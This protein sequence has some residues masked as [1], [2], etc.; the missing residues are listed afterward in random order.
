[1]IT[2]L[3]RS[4]GMSLLVVLG[5]L[6][7]VSIFAA[8][9]NFLASQTTQKARRIAAQKGAMLIARSARALAFA[10]ICRDITDEKSEI[11]KILINPSLTTEQKIPV[12]IASLTSLA[13]EFKQGKADLS[14][15]VDSISP[16]DKDKLTKTTGGFDEVER[17]IVLKIKPTVVVDGISYS[18]EELRQVKIFNLVPGILGKFS[19][20]VKEPESDYNKFAAELNGKVDDRVLSPQLPV[21]FKNG[22]TLDVGTKLDPTDLDSWKRR[23]FI[24]LGN[25]SLGGEI[26]LN[27]TAGSHPAYGEDFHF[28]NIAD[29]ESKNPDKILPGYFEPEPAGR[30]SDP[31]KSNWQECPQS[32]NPTSVTSNFAPFFYFWIKHQIKGFFTASPATNDDM[33]ADGKLAVYFK[34]SSGAPNTKMMSSVLHLFGTNSCPSPTLVLGNVFRRYAD[35]SAIVVDA[36]GDKYHDACLTYLNEAEDDTG[37]PGHVAKV[38][39][40]KNSA[41]GEK[42]LQVNPPSYINIDGFY[43]YNGLM[44]SGFDIY[45]SKMCQIITEPYLRSHDCLYH[46]TEDDF[47]PQAS[48]F[49]AA[50]GKLSLPTT[51]FKLDLPSLDPADPSPR[52]ASFFEYGSLSAIPMDYIKSKCVFTV[53]SY[54]DFMARFLSGPLMNQ[55][56]L[57]TGVLI[58]WKAGEKYVIPTDLNIVRGGIIVFE[59]GDVSVGKIPFKMSTDE[60]LIIV[61]LDGNIEITEDVVAA[62]LFAPNGQIII[63][64]TPDSTINGGV[65]VKKFLPNTFPNGG[66]IE[67]NANTDPSSK[68]SYNDYY[69]GMVS[70]I[71]SSFREI[72]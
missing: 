35:Y 11:F 4:R 62:S 13:A 2:R 29:V 57:D 14:V 9:M 56:N 32:S 23:G 36:T 28:F 49:P 47:F 24:Y 65:V 17:K 27:L 43:D 67:Y 16:L 66:K 63:N 3:S 20:F 6:V 48:S 22:G 44:P 71:A 64:N 33:N 58:K 53:N 8:S 1:M 38:K 68:A 70:N 40:C 55:L 52:A 41:L 59:K 42:P 7:V 50:P 30:L 18:F 39:V 37:I 12:N 26:D 10:Q 69:R 21:V 31:T 19:F 5:V 34:N 61:A 25:P 46:C 72:Q 54:E 60:F 45:K 51:T 15:T